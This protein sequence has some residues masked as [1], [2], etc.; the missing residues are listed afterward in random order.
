MKTKTRSGLGE[1]VLLVVVGSLVV[2][3]F[4]LSFNGD[5]GR[6]IPGLTAIC[7]LPT[8]II[9]LLILGSRK[10]TR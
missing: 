8:G 6:L 10:R 9:G 1:W 3:G 5:A 2:I 7:A 4:G